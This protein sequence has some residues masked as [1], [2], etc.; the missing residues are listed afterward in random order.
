MTP[1]AEPRYFSTAAAFGRW[2]RAHHGSSDALL[3]GF[4]KQGSGTASMSWPESVEEALCWGWIDGVRR[5]IDDARYSIRFTP[6]RAGS[7]W[8]ARNI[9]NVLRLIES[10][11]MQAE[12]LEA[13]AARSAE[14]S[15]VYAYEQDGA[16]L[17]AAD[18]SQFRADAG[19]WTFFNGQA[20]SY[21]RVCIHW[22]NTAQ[23]AET[24]ARRLAQ[25]IE[26]S[27]LR[28]RLR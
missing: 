15:Q 18:E 4:W 10:G 14:R 27:A 1:A 13:F 22:I 2:L 5:R 19:A 9:E 8:S 6:R 23:R 26:A 12:G 28:R 25:L 24:R 20:S 11:R 17:S 7:I 3:V 16:E 21:R